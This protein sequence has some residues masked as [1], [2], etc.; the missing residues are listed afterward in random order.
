MSAFDIKKNS[1]TSEARI[2]ARH[3]KPQWVR[4]YYITSHEVDQLLQADSNLTWPT[5]QANVL[6]EL[7]DGTNAQLRAEQIPEVTYDVFEWRMARAIQYR[8]ATVT[9]G[10]TTMVQL[11]V[12]VG[13]EVVNL[14]NDE[15]QTALHLAVIQKS[16][17]MVQLLLNAGDM[18]VNMQDNKGQTTLHLAVT[19]EYHNIEV[20]QMLVEVDRIG[21]NVQ[22]YK[23]KETALHLAS[24]DGNK[25]VISIL[26][27]KGADTTIRNKDGNCAVVNRT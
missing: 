21:L 24:Q 18:D 22:S 16:A 2:R 11:L 19:Q 5:M 17:T 13:K 27:K 7:F 9:E 15:G 26:V 3:N 8:I 1:T 4:F 12:E 23:E 6:T 10:S 14:Q 20:I 25:E